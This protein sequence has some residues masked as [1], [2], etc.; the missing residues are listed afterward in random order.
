[1]TT[2]DVELLEEETGLRY[3][4]VPSLFHLAIPSQNDAYYSILDDSTTLCDLEHTISTKCNFSLA[5]RTLKGNSTRVF[6]DTCVAHQIF[7]ALVEHTSL[8]RIEIRSLL[9]TLVGCGVL[10]LEYTGPK[11]KKLVFDADASLYSLHD[12]PQFEDWTPNVALVNE[13]LESLD[14]LS[15]VDTNALV[16]YQN[17]MDPRREEDLESVEQMLSVMAAET[18]SVM[19]NW[20]WD[21]HRVKGM[22]CQPEDQRRTNAGVLF[23]EMGERISRVVQF[24]STFMS[25]CQCNGFDCSVLSAQVWW[26]FCPQMKRFTLQSVCL[27]AAILQAAI[28]NVSTDSLPHQPAKI[29]LF[30]STKVEFDLET[31]HCELFHLELQGLCKTHLSYLLQQMDRASFEKLQMA[32]KKMNWKE[33][34]RPALPDLNYYAR[35]QADEF[36]T[37]IQIGSSPWKIALS[38]AH[39]ECLDLHLFYVRKLLQYKLSSEEIAS[40]EEA[41]FKWRKMIEK[42]CPDEFKDRIN[43]HSA[44]HLFESAKKFGPPRMIWGR[45]IERKHKIFRAFS[46]VY[47][48]RSVAYWILHREMLLSSIRFFYPDLSTRHTPK[49]EK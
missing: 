28:E 22:M 9:Q 38:K 3:D 40:A 48:S 29:P 35:Y 34:K 12:F 1:M 7:D 5:S 11:K 15:H 31:L 4:R 8:K 27:T 42:L 49:R 45:I 46:T 19:K 14:N 39:F 17:G 43:V 6:E 24:L 18:T 44:I 41:F 33:L 2:E 37:L 32:F 13:C 26:W 47:R 23:H 25:K 36:L 20:E 21:W 10:S 16:H 30:P